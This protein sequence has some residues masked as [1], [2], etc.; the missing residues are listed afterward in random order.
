VLVAGACLGVPGAWLDSMVD[1][2]GI[3]A[4]VP[5]AA[6]PLGLTARALMALVLGAGGGLVVWSALYLLWG[7]GGL[8]DRPA[9]SDAPVVRRADAH[10]DAPPRKPL[11]AADL[12]TPPAPVAPE[13]PIPVDLD[14]PLA[15]FD[16]A[17]ILPAPREPVR[18]PAPLP[19]RREPLGP[20]ERIESFPIAPPVDGDAAPS[21]EALLARLEQ[22]ARRRARRQAV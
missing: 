3:A 20:R 13:R 14:Q 6:P 21:I 4:L 11:S 10:P 12:G 1:G 7:P 18:V 9:A 17:A 8:F 15:R 16:P 5:A 19:I 22:G 2:S